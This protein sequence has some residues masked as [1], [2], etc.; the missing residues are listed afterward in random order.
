MGDARALALS[1]LFHCPPLVLVITP[2]LKACPWTRLLL[3]LCPTELPVCSCQS[4]NPAVSAL[5]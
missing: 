2:E 1:L 3:P 5:R 4:A